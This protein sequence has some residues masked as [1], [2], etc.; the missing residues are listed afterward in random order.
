MTAAELAERRQQSRPVL[1]A[2]TKDNCPHCRRQEPE[3]QRIANDWQES[4]DVAEIR[5]DHAPE[6]VQEYA[7]R[8]TPTL[9]LL[10]DGERLGSKHGFQRAQQIEA[11][12]AYHLG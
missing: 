7:L 5:V 8:G 9:V 11:F 1:A 3:T 10:R 4:L 12:L 6:L 2:F